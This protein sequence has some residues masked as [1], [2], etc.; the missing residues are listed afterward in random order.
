MNDSAFC[1][2]STAQCPIPYIPRE[3][4]RPDWEVKMVIEG[5]EESHRY[6]WQPPRCQKSMAAWL[7]RQGGREA[8]P[9]EG[10]GL[11]TST[12]LPHSLLLLPIANGKAKASPGCRRGSATEESKAGGRLSCLVHPPT[13]C[14]LG[15]DSSCVFAKL[16]FK[17]V[18]RWA[19]WWVNLCAS[20]DMVVWW[21]SEPAYCL[22]LCS[23]AR[24][25]Q[26]ILRHVLSVRPEAWP[27]GIP[28]ASQLFCLL[29][30]PIS[31]SSIWIS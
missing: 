13:G 17:F 26:Y 21:Y 24:R 29:L 6:S 3:C 27:Q 4:S 28:E 18:F 1:H 15:G 5:G 19:K 25:A 22:S 14:L 9:I 20:A 7:P 8:F 31:D 23:A 10:R 30:T 16:G 12:F 11:W 2:S